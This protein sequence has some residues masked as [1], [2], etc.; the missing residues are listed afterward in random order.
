[1]AGLFQVAI[2]DCGE[3]WIRLMVP[4]GGLD[5]DPMNFSK[6]NRLTRS[7]T[8]RLYQSNVLLSTRRRLIFGS[9][10]GGAK[11]AIPTSYLQLR[12]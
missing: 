10:H 11:Q 2:I 7:S 6:I 3:Q 1:M 4:R 12:R 8:C 5:I 9:R